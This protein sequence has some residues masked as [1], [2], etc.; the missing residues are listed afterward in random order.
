MNERR[1]ASQI[2]SYM[3]FITSYERSLNELGSWWEKVTLIGKINSLEVAATLL[4]DMGSTKGRFEALHTRLIT[5][6]VEQN[7]HKL[8]Q[9]TRARAQVAIDILIRNLFERTADVG[10]LATDE[11]I[12]TFL[13]EPSPSD[14]Q[15]QAIVA[16]LHEYTQKYSVYD[17]ILILDPQGHVQAHLDS[18]NPVEHSNDPLISATLCSREPYLETFRAS[19]LQL[20]RRD[21]HIFSARI[22]DSDAPNA[23]VLGVL[24][25]C[26]RF[27]DEMAGIFASL[28]RDGETVLLLDGQRIIAS[29]DPVRQGVGENIASTQGAALGLQINYH[30]DGAYLAC[31]AQTKGYQGYYGLGWQ[32]YVMQRAE[33][34]F[35]QHVKELSLAQ[36][37][38]QRSQCIPEAIRQIGSHAALVTDDLSLIVLNGQ[39]ISAKRDAKEFMPV[40]VE[41]RHIGERTKGLFE[42]SI[43]RLHSTVIHSLLSEVQFQAFLAV[44]IM[45]RNLYER[46]NDVRWWALTSRFRR[47]LAQLKHTE[48]DLLTLENILKY[49]NELYTVY[50]NLLLFDTER[51]VLAVSNGEQRRLIGNRLPDEPFLQAALSV[52]DTQRYVVSPFVPTELYDGRHTYVYS[53]AILAPNQQAQAVGGIAIV[54]DA[55]PQFIAMLE[56]ALPRDEHGQPLAGAFGLFAGRDGQII[57]STRQ[58]LNPGSSLALEVCFT[59]LDNG[60]RHSAILEYEGQHY[61][62]GGAMSQGYREYKTTGD[63]LND[64]LA[65]IFVPI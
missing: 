44:D 9:E 19:D 23:P 28:I 56:D 60:A 41:I 53:T 29:S 33:E 43:R 30:H 48:D 51:K 6:L 52:K 15:C 54:F 31:T 26:F 37:V 47:I 7:I 35:I 22:T 46:A 24:C 32:G 55:E 4:E 11:D 65:L 50:T 2:R 21:A 42:D 17:E 61:A 39:I 45:D 14:N 36:E 10:F 13:R 58:D 38:L 63:Y 18:D 20:G 12:R 34:A 49:I 16:R 27:E 64:V 59:K 5:N 62:V 8:E 1:L 40:L 25:L 3:P 57:A